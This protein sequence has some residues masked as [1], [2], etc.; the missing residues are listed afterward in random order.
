VLKILFI[1]TYPPQ[2]CGIATYTRALVRGVEEYNGGVECAIAVPENGGFPV[3]ARK[4]IVHVIR[5]GGPYSYAQAARW[6]NNSSY[7][8]VWLQ[9]EFGLFAGKWGRDI[10]TLCRHLRKPLITT[11]HTV[12]HDP[13]PDAR[14][15][16]RQL[17]QMSSAVMVMANTAVKILRTRY[18]VN[19]AK[20]FV[21]PH[22]TPDVPFVPSRKADKGEYAGHTL[23]STFGL[24]SRGKGL[25]N[26]ISALPTVVAKFPEV[27]YLIIGETHPKVLLE[28]GESYRESLVKLAEDLGVSGHVEFLNRYMDLQELLDYLRITDVYVTPYIGKEQIVSGALAYAVACGKAIVSTPYRY[29]AE[30]LADGRGLLV[31]FGDS[32]GMAEGVLTLLRNPEL[33]QDIEARC[34]A[35]GRSMTWQQVGAQH[36]RWARNVVAERRALLAKQQLTP[37]H[38]SAPVITRSQA[39]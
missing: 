11:L 24:I 39:S 22:G 18:K 12:M 31:D 33:K 30:V 15:I 3:E 6:I 21:V 27:K 36:I 25:E 37:L 13:D 34:Y 32:K 26:A 17:V 10:V 4:K 16:T 1:S 20:L 29:A 2:E 9:H 14:D 28:E 35:Y 5:N 19:P 38:I 8:V 23:L 7:D